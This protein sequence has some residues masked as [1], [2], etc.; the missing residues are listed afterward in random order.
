[1]FCIANTFYLHTIHYLKNE[2]GW[3]IRTILSQINAKIHLIYS[4]IEKQS[5]IIVTLC[6]DGL[7]LFKPFNY[8][9]IALVSNPYQNWADEDVRCK[10]EPVKEESADAVLHE[11]RH[12]VA[13]HSRCVRLSKAEVASHNRCVRFSKTEVAS[14]SSCLRLSKTEVASHSRCL[15][16]SKTEV[17][18]HNRC[19]RLNFA[20]VASH[21]RCLRLIFTEAAS[22]CLQMRKIEFS[23]SCVTLPK[24]VYIHRYSNGVSLKLRDSQSRYVQL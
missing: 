6:S 23:C 2:L 13:S 21:N 5:Y 14:H 4:N 15:R 7:Q 18:S 8:L 9:S 20:E 12:R 11:N 22:N 1:V 3:T 17:A 10:H 16:L 24:D 19:V